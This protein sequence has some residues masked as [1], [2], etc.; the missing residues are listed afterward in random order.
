MSEVDTV[1][2]HRLYVIIAP[3]P[4]HGAAKGCRWRPTVKWMV[5]PESFPPTNKQWRAVLVS[6]EARYSLRHISRRSSQSLVVDAL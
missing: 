4:D 5:G 6:R 1:L 2:D 3:S